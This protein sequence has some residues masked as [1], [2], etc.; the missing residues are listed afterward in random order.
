MERPIVYLFAIVL[1]ASCGGG[2]QGQLIG[3][4][5][6]PGWYDVDPYGMNY[7]GMGSF[8]MGP[9]DQ[10]VP[11]A[12][13]SKSK[14]VS[15]QA[16]YMDQTEITNNEYRQFVFYVRDSIAKRILGDE[17]IGEH[18]LTEDEFGEEID[19]PVI[20]WRERIDWY[21]DEEREALLLVGWD[22]LDHTRAAVVA[23]CS[24]SAFTK[25]LSR[26]RHRLTELMEPSTAT[27]PVLRPVPGKV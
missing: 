6:R 9:S 18:V 25:R 24:R 23:G 11:Y 1:L 4:Q 17:D 16:F 22:G 8:V 7:I 14:T 5:S 3:V 12:S 27:A 21:G 2:G 26:A 20:N 19:P 10:D 13:V 15:V